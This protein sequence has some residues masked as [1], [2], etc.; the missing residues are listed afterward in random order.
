MA[1][2][3]LSLAVWRHYDYAASGCWGCDQCT[4]GSY[5]GLMAQRGDC[6]GLLRQDVDGAR[7]TEDGRVTVLGSSVL[8]DPQ[9]DAI[10]LDR[11]PWALIGVPGCPRPEARREWI[12][13]AWDAWEWVRMGGS[14]RDVIPRPTHALL[15]LVLHL[16]R[17]AHALDARRA[18]DQARDASSRG[19]R[20]G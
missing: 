13:E 9:F 20:R 18:A 1:R 19:G 3:L 12:G 17:E 15:D 7:V 6:G 16:E 10:E 5:P 14:V 4:G 11:C 2:A 8:N